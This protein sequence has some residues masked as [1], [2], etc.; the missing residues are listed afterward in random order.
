MRLTK[1]Y[2]RAVRG[3]GGEKRHK[4]RERDHTGWHKEKGEVSE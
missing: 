1:I 3:G 4:L 2:C